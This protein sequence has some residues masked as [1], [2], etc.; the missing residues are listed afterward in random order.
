MVCPK[1][2]SEMVTTQVVTDTKLVKKH[3]GIFWWICVGWWWIPLKWL[4]FTI[5]AVFLWLIRLVTGGR[6]K[7]VTTHS[8]VCVC[9]NCG[10]TWKVK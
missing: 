3:H 7:F 2:K 5:P 4:V 9:Q 6:K 8:T 1:C 10:H